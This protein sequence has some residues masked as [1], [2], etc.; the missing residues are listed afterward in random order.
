MTDTYTRDEL[1]AAVA[2][3]YEAAAENITSRAWPDEWKWTASVIADAIRDLTPADAFAALAERDRR[4][5]AEGMR[6][7][8]GIAKNFAKQE[9]GPLLQ[10]RLAGCGVSVSGSAR[11]RIA[12]RIA[13]DI[14]DR[15][16]GN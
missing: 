4:M 14:I 8:V 15:M 12:V 3:A 5:K 11:R 6:E 10:R 2:A 16:D 7:A 9:T 13:A 1:D